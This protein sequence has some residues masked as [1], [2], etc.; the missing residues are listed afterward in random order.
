[1]LYYLEDMPPSVRKELIY[2]LDKSLRYLLKALEK[3]R[4]LTADSAFE[5][6]KSL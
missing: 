4:V 2:L 6:R 5:H 3:D 1:M